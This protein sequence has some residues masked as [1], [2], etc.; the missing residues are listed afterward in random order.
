M[1]GQTRTPVVGFKKLWGGVVA[2]KKWGIEKYFSRRRQSLETYADENSITGNL[3]QT[4]LDLG[5]V[6][7]NVRRRAVRD[8]ASL[9]DPRL[10][11]PLSIAARD[12][13]RDVQFDAIKALEDIAENIKHKSL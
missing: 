10:V 12:W 7:V 6:D 13:N 3:K 1:K 8:L 4:I 2:L 9:T 11:R 5:S